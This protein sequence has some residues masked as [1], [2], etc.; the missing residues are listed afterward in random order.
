MSDKDDR[1]FLAF[2]YHCYTCTVYESTCLFVTFKE[3]KTNIQGKT[4]LAERQN[5][6][7]Q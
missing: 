3:G 1:E 5:H 4:T 2:C 6:A 7:I